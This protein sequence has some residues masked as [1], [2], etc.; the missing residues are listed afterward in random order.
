MTYTHIEIESTKSQTQSLCSGQRLLNTV[1]QS[2]LKQCLGFS[3]KQ[4]SFFGL[5]GFLALNKNEIDSTGKKAKESSKQATI[6]L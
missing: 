5:A 4:Q 6:F 2:R 1:L 3:I